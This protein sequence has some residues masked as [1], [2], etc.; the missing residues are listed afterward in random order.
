MNQ[1]LSSA[2][3][4][5]FV[6]AK[7]LAALGPGFLFAG[8]A[9]GTSH[10]VQATR[11]GAEYGIGL[12]GFILL[13]ILIKYPTFFFGP[14][15]VSVTGKSLIEGYRQT[16]GRS[17]VALFA[18]VQLPMLAIIIA[19]IAI[20]TA[21]LAG[22][23]LSLD[24]SAPAIAT[25]LITGGCLLTYTGGY[26]MLDWVNK[27]FIVIL[28][29]T[30]LLATLA[31]WPM[32]DWSL[33]P[34]TAASPLYSAATLVTLVAVLGL[35]PSDI[36]LA[37]LNS[38]WSEARN[39][40]RGERCDTEAE[41][42]DFDIG[43]IGAA[44]LAACFVIM[45]AGVMH[46]QGITPADGAVGFASQVVGLYTSTLGEWS[47]VVV[48]ISAFTVMLTTLLTVLDGFPRM[49][50][51]AYHAITRPE[52]IEAETRRIEGSHAYLIA[53][54]A[55]SLLAILILFTL[56][57]NF[58]LFMDFV[59]VSAFL[60]SPILAALNHFTANGAS[61]PLEQ[62]PSLLINAWSLLA[63]ATLVLLSLGYLFV[64]FIH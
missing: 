29:L 34:A 12:L 36:T 11:A 10:V 25:V 24:L 2:A 33:Y 50:T 18:L 31:A 27:V 56:M 43:Y 52:E 47:G 15:Y 45:G 39:K 19:A 28:T 1:P 30:T 64:R 54:L 57:G 35:M 32:V 59:M 13:A 62:R 7:Y 6:P 46:G 58:R 40:T 4:A 60:L 42:L 26:R 37:I 49:M 55:L 48:G 16:F 23:L 9:I 38:L 3:S 63:I 17:V 8:A 51:A 22:T 41:K 53:M 44:I 5:R 61:V 21:G 20:T 14:F